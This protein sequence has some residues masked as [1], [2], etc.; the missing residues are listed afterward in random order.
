[1]NLTEDEQKASA[2]AHEL[3]LAWKWDATSIIDFHKGYEKQ[4][5]QILAEAPYYLELVDAGNVRFDTPGYFSIARRTS[6]K[7]I[8]LRFRSI[9][10]LRDIAAKKVIEILILLSVIGILLS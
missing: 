10:K 4:V 7:I 2:I 5:T 1:M 8:P 6:F 9:R 3:Y